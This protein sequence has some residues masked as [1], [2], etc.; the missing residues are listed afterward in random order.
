MKKSKIF[1]IV[2]LTIFVVAL[3]PACTKNNQNTTTPPQYRI[4]FIS[5]GYT[6]KIIDWEEGMTTVTL[7]EDPQI[8]NYKFIGWYLEDGT[9]FDGTLTVPLKEDLKVYARF[10]K[11]EEPEPQKYTIT[12]DSR[13]GSE[14]PSTITD[15]IQSSPFTQKEG[16][17]FSGWYT[18]ISCEDKYK[19]DFP[20][21]PDKDMTL[22]AG[23]TEK[24]PETYTVS[25][26][27][28]G[29][30]PVS[31]VETTVIESSPF[32]KRDNFV[33]KGW[34][35]DISCEEIYKVSFPFYPSKDITLYAGWEEII[36]PELLSIEG[37]SQK[38]KV[39]TMDSPVPSSQNTLDLSLLVNVTENAQWSLYNDEDCTSLIDGTSLQLN[40][41]DNTFYIKVYDD[42]YSNVYEL[43]IYRNE[44]FKVEV[45]L[46]NSLA[47]TII[48]DKGATIDVDSLLPDMKIQKVY[49][50]ELM[51]KEW[52]S[53]EPVTQ[54]MK[55]YVKAYFSS[56]SVNSSG[57]LSLVGNTPDVPYDAYIPSSI[58]NQ[59]VLSLGNWL[60]GSDN[61][62][63]SITFEEGIKE[64]GY[65]SFGY[66]NGLEEVTLPSSLTNLSEYAFYSCENL[67]KVTM[68]NNVKTIGMMAFKYCSSLS[69]INFS[70]SLETI[71]K[72]AF[73]S[74]NLT[75]VQLPQSIEF[76]DFSVFESNKNLAEISLPDKVIDIQGYLVKDTAFALNPAN[77]Q[78]NVLYIGKHLISVSKDA[79]S[80]TVK[81]DTINISGLACDDAT[82]LTNVVFSGNNIRNIYYKA[83]SNTKIATLDLKDN[84]AKID[85]NA[86][87]NIPALTNCKDS[88]GAV[89]FGKTLIKYTGTSSEYKV[90][91]GTLSIADN[92]ASTN[93]SITSITLPDSLKLVGD[94]AFE[95]CTNLNKATIN[96]TSQIEYIGYAAF[97]S[98]AI[99][100]INIPSSVKIINDSAFGFCQNLEYVI[101]PKSCEYVGDYAFNG[102]ENLYVY[103]EAA[104]QPESWHKNW[105]Y[106]NKTSHI[107]YYSETSKDGCWHYDQENMPVIW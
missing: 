33:F 37:F 65:Y 96:S 102:I 99:S 26:D 92:A 98:T 105:A 63:R 39:F 36:Y 48:V 19:V 24:A 18:D 68:E 12:F 42:N 27:A 70:K 59:K 5:N 90:K 40:F 71:G 97:R 9:P 74:C 69:D 13:G 3:V 84:V 16:F 30:S 60:F 2:L 67:K 49:T 28:L 45:Y 88:D 104:S 6:L 93:T 15:K 43:N 21:A 50:D 25:F 75:S 31:S 73:S 101:I 79:T 81:E 94:Y 47:N 51:T 62:L 77:W 85:K 57:V 80:I 8:E 103:C 11:I 89:Y 78:D 34:Y 72:A 58:N 1:L 91:E 86:F 100:A 87:D 10:S 46:N 44:G 95:R 4:H 52:T 107:Y 61:N 66:C 22:Y 54:D 29:G 17:V 41:K 76:L 38:D 14:V 23:W 82:N 56:F 32:T 7:P 55:L 83:F 106:N 64:L 53:S 35:T 20:F